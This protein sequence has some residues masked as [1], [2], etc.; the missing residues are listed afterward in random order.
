ERQEELA[1]EH[2]RALED[3]QAA[4]LCYA[5]ELSEWKHRAGKD[6]AD[7][8]APPEKPMRPVMGRTFTDD[9]TMEALGRRLHES[10]RGI[11]FMRD[12]IAGWVRGMNQY[13]GGNGADRQRWLSI[14]SG[15]TLVIDRVK[16]PDPLIIRRPFV[17]VCGC[18]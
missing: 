14:W 17:S 12:E 15:E 7:A 5:A 3:Y 9:A 13:R 4:E 10:P 6:R 18:I 11:V 8:G 16:D 2:R 1:A